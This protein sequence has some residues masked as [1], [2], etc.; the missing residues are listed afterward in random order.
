MLSHPDPYNEVIELNYFLL[1]PDFSDQVWRELDKA[2]DECSS[3]W[4]K[5]PA[6]YEISNT[7]GKWLQ[8]EKSKRNTAEP[9]REPE[10]KKENQLKRLGFPRFS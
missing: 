10:E 8:G 3:W 2:K 5:K 7:L 9:E 1:N 6:F 4:V